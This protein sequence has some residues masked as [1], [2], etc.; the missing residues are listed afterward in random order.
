[1]DHDFDRFGSLVFDD[2]VMKATLPPEIWQKLHR[3]I[4]EG[5]ALRPDVADAV[6]GAMKTWAIEHGATHFTHWFQPMTGIT[7]EKHESFISPASDGQ[8]LAEFSGREL[9]RGG[10]SVARLNGRIIPLSRLRELGRLLVN[11]HGQHEHTLLLEEE[12]QLALV[13]GYGGA[14]A[15]SAGERAETIR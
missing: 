2:R 14:E 11:I 12:R 13:D 5:K 6:A 15:A 7:A 3:T 8:V 4:D 1:M 9:I 10:R